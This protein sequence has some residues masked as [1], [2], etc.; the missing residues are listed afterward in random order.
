MTLLVSLHFL[1]R[2]EKVDCLRC[3]NKLLHK[4]HMNLFQV[5]HAKREELVKAGDQL[6]L[7]A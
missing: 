2:E 5:G 4:I 6:Y 7:C 1:L 3:S